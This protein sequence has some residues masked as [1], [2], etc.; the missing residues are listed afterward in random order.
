M[1][2]DVLSSLQVAVASTVSKSIACVA[3]YPH[4]VLRSRFQTQHH[5]A[6]LGAHQ[7]PI[8]TSVVQAC[9]GIYH[10]E[11][12]RG[13]YRGLSITLLR[14]VPAC[15]VTFVSY[16]KILKLLAEAGAPHA[17]DEV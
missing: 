2:T 17:A 6:S 12:L 4:E 10:A 5:L 15:L 8:Y 3:A 16:E 9:K 7:G 13:F 1:A 14:S 11:G